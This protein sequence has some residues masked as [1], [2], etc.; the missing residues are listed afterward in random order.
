MD[1]NNQSDLLRDIV[2]GSIIQRAGMRMNLLGIKTERIR[3][4]H[5]MVP[6]RQSNSLGKLVWS[7]AM[8][9]RLNNH[10]YR[11]EHEVNGEKVIKTV[12]ALKGHVCFLC[13]KTR[14]E[15]LTCKDGDKCEARNAMRVLDN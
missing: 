11:E 2:I 10:V 15:I 6:E 12:S 8:Y 3:K 4:E 9:E 13:H 7:S 5:E 1:V 14:E